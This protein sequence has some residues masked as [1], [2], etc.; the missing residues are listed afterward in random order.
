M[1]LVQPTYSTNVYKSHEHPESNEPIAQDLCPQLP[2]PTIKDFP[3]AIHVFKKDTR[4]I[5]SS[6]SNLATRSIAVADPSSQSCSS[7]FSKV[8]LYDNQ[9]PA[10]RLKHMKGISKIH[11]H[12]SP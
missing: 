10:L 8:C 7:V 4:L 9:H 1:S 2:S 6:I 11:G 5:H 12:P 3:D